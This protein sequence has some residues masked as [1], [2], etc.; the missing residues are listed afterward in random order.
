[1]RIRV[2]NPH[3]HGR[4]LAMIITV[5]ILVQAAVVVTDPT[6]LQRGDIFWLPL[7]TVAVLLCVSTPTYC[8]HLSWCIVYG[9]IIG[10][11]PVVLPIVSEVVS[12]QAYSSFVRPDTLL[13]FATFLVFG[14]ITGIG[15]LSAWA[16][17]YRHA[18]CRVEIQDGTLCPTCAYCITHLPGSICPE[19]GSEFD[20]GSIKEAGAAMGTESPPRRRLLI[21][22]VVLLSAVVLVSAGARWLRLTPPLFAMRSCE[23]WA[24]VLRGA[25]QPRG[26]AFGRLSAILVYEAKHGRT[27]SPADV[28]SILGPPDLFMTHE[29]ET[30]YLYF[31]TRPRPW[32]AY[33]D[34]IDG[35]LT[36]GGGNARGINNLSRWQPYGKDH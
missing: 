12:E 31:Y 26:D 28:R 25:D 18:L 21:T 11:A 15:V 32:E 22:C 10:A 29:S 14:A 8:Q 35:R 30:H 5:L 6:L 19:C 33:L 13:V 24:I 4:L 27:I 16:L 17:F 34:F 3:R 9:A 7:M 2:R 1:M 23:Y 20:L 36:G